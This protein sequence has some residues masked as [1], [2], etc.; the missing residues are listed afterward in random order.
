MPQGTS[1]KVVTIHHVQLAM[2]EGGEAEA[3]RF[4]A[5]L[6]AI[7]EVAKPPNLAARGCWFEQVGLKIHLGVEKDFLPAR[8]AHPAFI[9]DDLF[10]LIARLQAAGFGVTEG[11]ALPELV[12][13]YVNDA[14]GKRIEL[15][16]SVV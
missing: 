8:K 15:L 3:R 5:G 12:R 10:V 4:Y 6:L 14:F 1:G 13:C 9:V 7:P 2:P 11:E 16:Q